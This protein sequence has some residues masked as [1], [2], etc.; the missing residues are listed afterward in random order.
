MVGQ[1][2]ARGREGRQAFVSSSSGSRLER[3]LGL[4]QGELLAIVDTVNVSPRFPGQVGGGRS[5]DLVPPRDTC[6][7]GR[8]LSMLPSYDRVL[9]CGDV[10]RRRLG[11]PYR[12]PLEWFQFGGSTC[13]LVPHPSGAN[14]WWNDRA[15]VGSARR[16]MSSVGVSS[17]LEFEGGAR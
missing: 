5:G 16:F 14:R 6:R 13:A 4:Q 17:R 3:L 9:I 10:A 7:T 1:A 11:C 2:P 12:Q 8:I 15:N